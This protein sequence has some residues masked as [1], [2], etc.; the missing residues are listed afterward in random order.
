MIK[1]NKIAAVGDKDTVLAFKALGFS[2]FYTT[3]ADELK[4]TILDLD[5]KSYSLI[6]IPEYEAIRVEEFLRTYDTRP[7]PIILT[8]PDGRGDGNF[9]IQKL[10]QNM[11]RAVGSATALK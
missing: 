8:I 2:T 7:Y 9:A 3:T 11:L 5:K 1:E 6:F 10:V 4:Q